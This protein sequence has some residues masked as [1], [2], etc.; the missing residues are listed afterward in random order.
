MNILE[1]VLYV[2]NLDSVCISISLSHSHVDWGPCGP[3]IGDQAILWSPWKRK[4]GPKPAALVRLTL[5]VYYVK[6]V[7]NLNCLQLKS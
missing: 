5:E 4:H 3:W 6:H 2:S 1:V 7:E